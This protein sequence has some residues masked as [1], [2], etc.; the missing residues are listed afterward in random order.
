MVWSMDYFQRTLFRPQVWQV[1]Y[2]RRLSYLDSLTSL[3]LFIRSASFPCFAQSI[4]IDKSK[5]RRM[6]ESANT[7][8]WVFF[9]LPKSI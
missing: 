1:Q 4:L 9:I 2:A 7:Y 5:V 6:D 8:K 3:I